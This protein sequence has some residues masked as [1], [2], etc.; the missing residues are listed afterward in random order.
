MHSLTTPQITYLI[1]AVVT[2]VVLV[3]DR[4]RVDLVGLLIILALALTGILSPEQAF[5]GLGSEPALVIA[6][7]FVLSRAL[8]LTRVADVVTGWIVRLAGATES[9]MLAVVMLGV[10]AFSTFT[11]HVTPTAIMLP[12]LLRLSRERNIPASKLLMPLSFAASLGS[13]IAIIGAPAFL[14]ASALL[15][16]AGR[17]ALGLFSIAPIGLLLSILG[18]LYV[19]LIG[20]F[21]LPAHRGQ[22][23]GNG[24]FEQGRY[25]A[26]VTIPSESAL[27]GEGPDRFKKL[28]LQS[29]EILK[30]MR[31]D[32]ALNSPG[33]STR[34]AAGDTLLVRLTSDDLATLRQEPEGLKLKP[35]E[36]FGLPGAE[37]Q[38]PGEE[39]NARLAQAVVM[40][41]SD[42]IGCTISKAGL[43]RR[44][45]IVVVALSRQGAPTSE[46]IDRV[47]LRAGDVLVLEGDEEEVRHLTE[48]QPSLLMAPFPGTP[49]PRTAKR[50]AAIMLGV[51]AIASLN[52]FPLE[53]VVV[54]G[55]VA[56]VLF[57]CITTNQA[58]EAVDTRIFLF[59]AG[60]IPLGMAM[61]KT[62][63][64]ALMGQLLHS[65]IGNLP[66]F[67]IL[68][69]IFAA[70]GLL[71]QVLSDT[72]TLSVF[73]PVAIAFAHAMG[74]PP[75]PYVLAVAFA[76][77]TSFLTPIAHW[78]N[79]LVFNPGQYRFMDFVKV[80]TPLTILI[81]IVVA[82]M[83]PMIFR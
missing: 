50:A 31:C 42:L 58:Y 43:Q 65:W 41:G 19:L 74:R 14:F 36:R 38:T 62:G 18:V 24:I 71:T 79:L 83:G 35:I 72:A 23:T 1:I 20:R 53:V 59:I 48:E 37:T 69:A 39:L 80:G 5:S 47:L 26:E 70:S 45:G 54:A 78:G 17:P 10:S 3:T 64:A 52:V 73:G 44:Y 6:A 22:G 75:E 30:W 68:L 7:I 40:P 49:R 29:F 77:V 13:T 66:E 51:I 34:F 60:A 11:E 82:W 55:A 57:G 25:L 67:W 2:L 33:E 15:Q 8:Q 63:L 81:A 9:R 4:L 27:V 46:A 16:K 61:Q 56:M 76:S 28:G 21:L 32:K 12:V